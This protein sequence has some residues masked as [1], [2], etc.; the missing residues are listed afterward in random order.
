MRLDFIL[1]LLLLYLMILVLFR[2]RT[3]MSLDHGEKTPMSLDHRE[4]THP[5]MEIPQE[6]VAFL[7]HTFDGYQ[8]YWEPWIHFFFKFHPEPVWPVYFASEKVPIRNNCCLPILTGKGEWGQR[9]I[10][11]L[12]QI[13]E[14]YIFYFQEDIWLTE[15][16]TQNYLNTAVQTL[17]KNDLNYLKLQADCRFTVHMRDNWQDRRWY[18]VSHHPGLWKKSYLLSTLQA[19]MTPF[20][21]EITINSYLHRHPQEASKCK[22]NIEFDARVFPYLDASKRGKLCD[23]GSKMMKKD[24]LKLQIE[25]DAVLERKD[26]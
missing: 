9:L 1:F 20:K 25:S 3:P 13:P 6:H 5:R 24:G 12:Q 18:I 26:Q 16:L 19:N 4:K 17:I 2:P 8:R 22:C 11:A 23:E 10:S 21:H 15:E 7:V 14:E